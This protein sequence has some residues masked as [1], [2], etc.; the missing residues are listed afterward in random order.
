MYDEDRHA[1][2]SECSDDCGEAVGEKASLRFFVAYE[3]SVWVPCCGES[4]S[5]RVQVL[6]GATCD[7]DQVRPHPRELRECSG[8][9]FATALCVAERAGV[10]QTK[11]GE[12]AAREGCDGHVVARAVPCTRDRLG[13]MTGVRVADENDRPACVRDA[14]GA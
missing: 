1:S 12:R 11:E 8:Y 10:A 6:V 14:P 5:S 3:R 9:E 13:E 7:H 2:I 4:D